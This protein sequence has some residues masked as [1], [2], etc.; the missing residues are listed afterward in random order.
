GSYD[1]GGGIQFNMTALAIRSAGSTNAVSQLH[2]EVTRAMFA[3]MWPEVAEA[4]RPVSFVTNGVHVPTWI[5]ADLSDL[6]TTYLGAG[7]IGS[8]T[9]RGGLSRSSSP[10][11]RTR[12]TTSASTTC[13]A[14]TSAR[15]IRSSAAASPSSTT[16][17]CTS[18]ISWSRVATSG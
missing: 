13:S 8:S 9:P 3:P 10:A 17:T 7:W 4:D 11:S 1:N 15:S 6:F 16:T 14:S 18:R 12:P 2:G 5:A